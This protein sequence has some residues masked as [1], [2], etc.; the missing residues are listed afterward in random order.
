MFT[1]QTS[2]FSPLNRRSEKTNGSKFAGADYGRTSAALE[3]TR[4][5]VACADST[6][7]DPLAELGLCDVWRA[8]LSYSACF[9]GNFPRELG[10]RHRPC[11][12]VEEGIESGDEDK[13]KPL[14][15][16][17]VPNGP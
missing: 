17:M 9:D 10:V 8:L 11:R 7:S 13:E 16:V 15:P 6:R 12:D 4:E 2:S 5:A 14:L 3:D 1:L